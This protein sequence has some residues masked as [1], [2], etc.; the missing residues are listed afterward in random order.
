MLS[1]TT[2]A[3]VSSTALPRFTTKLFGCSRSCATCS[4]VINAAMPPDALQSAI[5]ERN[6]ERHRD[7][8]AVRFDD[9]PQL[10]RDEVLDFVGQAH[11]RSCRPGVATSAGSATSPYTETTAINVGTNARNA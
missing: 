10:E 4:P 8:R 1:S 11:S 9:R 5:D 3:I 6:R 2:A 7:A